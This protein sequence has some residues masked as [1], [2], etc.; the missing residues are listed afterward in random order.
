MYCKNCGEELPEKA[1]FCLNCG[2]DLSIQ[3]EPVEEIENVIAEETVDEVDASLQ[4]IVEEVTST[5]EEPAVENEVPD[6]ITTEPI[7]K[8][9]GNA[10]RN[11]LSILCAALI[12]IVAI[13]TMSV[14]SF[15]GSITET[16]LGNILEEIDVREAFEDEM[17]QDSIFL[18]LRPSEAEKIYEEGTLKEFIEGKVYECF[19]YILGGSEPGDIYADDF[20]ELI[21]ENEDIIL[22]ETGVEL[23]ESDYESIEE[24]GEN[25]EDS[26][27][28]NEI[29]KIVRTAC[30]VLVII[31]LVL[32]IALLSFAIFK[33]RKRKIETLHWIGTT[34]T[35]TAI[36]T[37]I[38][39]VAL[40]IL[41]GS[42]FFISAL[43]DMVAQLYITEL[44]GVL[45]M[46]GFVLLVVGAL[47]IVTY[48]LIAGK[49][50]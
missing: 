14:I 9:K 8:E 45:M 16:H 12:F 41:S 27:K 24:F 25:L 44:F 21:E 7:K 36:I 17:V 48:K 31:V 18:D 34:L 49:K 39:G 11:I 26:T 46:N 10:G 32:V 37:L 4:E 28:V 50:K 1:K 19:E 29:V 23:S 22:E 15:R 6:E 40:K 35:L 30:S 42:V 3:E 43:V 13:V 20:V 38:A 2:F 5:M 47:M 33:I